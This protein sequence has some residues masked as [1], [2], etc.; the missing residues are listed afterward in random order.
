MMMPEQLIS[1][2]I[3][4]LS[5]GTPEKIILDALNDKNK[6]ISAEIGKVIVALPENKT[7]T[8]FVQS[9]YIKNKP[10]VI[11]KDTE[12]NYLRLMFDKG[13]V[14]QR[15]Y[16]FSRIISDDQ[17]ECLVQSE[18]KDLISLRTFF[19]LHRR[20]WNTSF[21]EWLNAKTE[22]MRA[23]FQGATMGLMKTRGK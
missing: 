9:Y 7:G 20:A 13:A 10:D 14:K 5:G 17:Q 22:N 12:Y 16:K 19:K 2:A 11:I 3:N 23:L 6:I 18:D 8:M 21:Q 4:D 1:E 15:A